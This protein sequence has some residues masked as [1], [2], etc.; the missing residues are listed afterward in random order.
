MEAN[1]LYHINLNLNTNGVV[2][3]LNYDIG[4]E[5]RARMH[6]HNKGT[7]LRS[8]DSTVHTTQ[9]EEIR[10]IICNTPDFSAK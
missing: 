9:T 3:N 10:Q 8:T 1:E 2:N 7:M 4:L 6:K 5:N